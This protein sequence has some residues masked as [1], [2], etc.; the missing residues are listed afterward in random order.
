[1]TYVDNP[2]GRPATSLA[3]GQAYFTQDGAPTCFQTWTRKADRRLVG[4]PVGCYELFG[5]DRVRAVRI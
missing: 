5:N 2:T 1:M 3:T 4:G